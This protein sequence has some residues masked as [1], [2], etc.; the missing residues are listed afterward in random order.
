MRGAVFSVRVAEI[1]TMPPF[2]LDSIT[3]EAGAAGS[4]ITSPAGFCEAAAA[5]TARIRDP[6]LE[7]IVSSKVKIFFAHD[8]T[9]DTDCGV[10]NTTAD[11]DQSLPFTRLHCPYP[12]I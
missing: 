5:W 1:L 12:E 9:I 11:R 8:T 10:A 3:D 7:F 2:E 4:S 6:V